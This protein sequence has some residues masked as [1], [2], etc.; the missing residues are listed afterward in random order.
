M[1]PPRLVFWAM[2]LFAGLSIIG[3]SR[4]NADVVVTLEDVTFA[5]GGTAS[6]SFDL[7][8][9][10]YLVSALITTTAGM[11]PGAGSLTGY[12]YTAANGEVPSGSAPFDS[13]F[14]F[15][16]TADNI[17]LILLADAPVTDGGSDPLIVGAGSPG[18][19]AVSNEYCTEGAPACGTGI[20][21][22]DGRLITDGTLYAPEPTTLSL[23]GSGG[24]LL[25]LIRRRRAST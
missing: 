2:M 23:L 21:Q 3:T 5:D 6:G 22:F 1:K 14:Y 15:S 17:S 8:V 7:N 18:S 20:N 4:A 9:Y 10:G 16:S 12:T 24:V 19:L 13:V 11:S 25:P